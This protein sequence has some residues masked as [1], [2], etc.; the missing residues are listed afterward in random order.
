MTKSADTEPSSIDRFF[1]IS[2]R[3]ST[4]G[5]EIRGGLT[6]FLAMSYII[7]LNPILIGAAADS[8]GKFLGGTDSPNLAAVAAAT[9]LVSGILTIVM[10]LVGNFPMAVSS[11]LGMS[12]FMAFGVVVIPGMTWADAMGLVIIEG[13][14]LLVL[15][16]TGFRT[17][18]FNSVPAQLKSAI[19]VGI[20]FFI[21]LIGMINAGFIQN[22]GGTALE[23]GQ[24]GSIASWPVLLFVVAL[25]LLFVLFANEVR[26]AI[27]YTI[28]IAT[29]LAFAIEAI[30]HLGP[31]T[32]PDGEVANPGGWGLTVPKIEGG[33]FHS[34][35]LSILGSFNLLGSFQSVG[36][37]TAVLVV[38]TLLLTNFFDLLGTMM[39]VG[40]QAD[41]VRK[42]G[43]VEGSKRIMIA[44]AVGAIAGGMGG[45]S[46]NSGFVESTVGVG[47]GARTGLANIVTGLLFLLTVFLA[48]IA[49]LI[50]SE[51]A[52]PTLVFVG[53]LMMQQV[54]RINWADVEIAVPAFLTIVLM[55]FSY[56]ITN[57]IGAGFIAYTVLKAARGKFREVHPLMYLTSALFVVYFASG[58]IQSLLAGA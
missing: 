6:T 27:L 26:A 36:I 9:S 2:Q 40:T 21:A 5:T 29:V 43:E 17:A 22:S 1:K 3:G 55:P 32:G 16:V 12:A 39:A 51:A 4:V 57:G 10:G 54:V 48:P 15:V 14:I 44:D 7:V 25:L 47:S 49:A 28:L 56:S 53:F 38:F 19:G 35:D 50:P 24:G 23:L 8:S 41:L 52:A 11:A 45:T 37:V 31:K 13:V 18:I 30:F 33:W 46:A 20:G 34:P 58:P 42:D